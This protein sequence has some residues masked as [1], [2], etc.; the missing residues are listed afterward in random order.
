[1][2]SNESGVCV[3]AIARRSALSIVLDFS[4][5]AVQRPLAETGKDNPLDLI[6]LAEELPDFLN[7]DGRCALQRIAINA[8]ADSRKGNRFDLV[9]HRERQAI[10][11]A[12]RQPLGLTM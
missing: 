3:P 2:A 9:F 4:V 10:P 1:M 8:S 11:V 5:V 12:V 7:R 6:L